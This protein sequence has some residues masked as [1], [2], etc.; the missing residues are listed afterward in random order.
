MLPF[1]RD[2]AMLKKLLRYVCCADT[3]KDKP[4]RSYFL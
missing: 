1:E 4:G 2:E 3:G